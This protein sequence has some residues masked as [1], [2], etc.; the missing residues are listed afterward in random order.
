MLQCSLALYQASCSYPTTQKLLSHNILRVE[1]KCGLY[2]RL[3][4]V[5]D[6]RIIIYFKLTKIIS[7]KGY[8]VEDREE[9]GE[10]R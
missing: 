10:D 4:S 7:P 1:G 2:S 5:L 8:V 9:F 3:E 6:L